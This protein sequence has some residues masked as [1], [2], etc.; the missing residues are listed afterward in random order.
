MTP[1]SPGSWPYPV[2]I[3]GCSQARPW[4]LLV[5]LPCC[6]TQ[7]LVLLDGVVLAVGFGAGL[8]GS[9]PSSGP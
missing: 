1:D 9:Y 4:D 2:Q 6:R 3:Q 7:S 5:S 8:R